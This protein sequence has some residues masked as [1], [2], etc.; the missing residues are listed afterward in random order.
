M[1]SFLWTPLA[2]MPREV[3][4]VER[5]RDLEDLATAECPG[6]AGPTLSLPGVRELWIQILPPLPTVHVGASHFTSLRLSLPT[7]KMTSVSLTFQDQRACE[8]KA[9]NVFSCQGAQ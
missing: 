4:L 7:Y 3:Q 8:Q 6:P 5:R 1:S 9:P 2:Q